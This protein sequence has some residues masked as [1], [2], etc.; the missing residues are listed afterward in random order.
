MIPTK[1]RPRP[2]AELYASLLQQSRLSDEVIIV[3]QSGSDVG[4]QAVEALHQALESRGRPKL[5][6]VLDPSVRGAAEARNVGFQRSS[7]EL[8]AF[9][10]DDLGLDPRAL[11]LMEAAFLRHPRLL[12]ASGI[13]TNCP[14]PA[15]HARL[16]TA[17][18]F[19]GPFHDERQKIYRRWRQYSDGEIVPTRKLYG[20][21]MV[22]RRS[23]FQSI[24]G[25]DPRYKGSSVGEDIEISQRLLRCRPDGEIAFVGGVW[26]TNRVGGEWRSRDRLEETLIVSS[27]YLFTKN[28]PHSLK[29]RCC[30]VWLNVG[31]FLIACAASV[32]RRKLGPIRSL[33]RG[34]RSVR[35]GYAG[36]A[37]LEAGDHGVTKRAAM[38]TLAIR[39]T[40]K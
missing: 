10:D 38:G 31:I 39:D 13:V 7:G 11:A 12:A 8:I 20:G 26:V 21:F 30:F 6:Y 34:I 15:R 37:F 5:Q 22:W 32:R 4:R 2:V 36:C 33:L 28:A 27:H 40:Q 24:G 29:T 16:T 1:D 25:F 17:T 23:V 9:I 18:F 19:L 3:D 35:S 14:L